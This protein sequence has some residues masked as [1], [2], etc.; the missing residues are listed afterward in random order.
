MK[1]WIIKK[2]NHRLLLLGGMN[3]KKTY[4]DFVIIFH[5][6]GIFS[7]SFFIERD[8]GFNYDYHYGA[9]M[10]PVGYL[11]KSKDS[12]KIELKL[13][14]RDLGPMNSN[15]DQT[16]SLGFTGWGC[17]FVPLNVP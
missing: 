1:F 2:L 16:D 9:Q 17:Y 10:Y 14:P 12:E 4:L 3:L 15:Q 13:I 11:I 8:S 7:P 6:F 5:F